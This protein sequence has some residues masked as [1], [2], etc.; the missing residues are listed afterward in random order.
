LT[1]DRFPVLVT[2]GAGYIGSHAVLALTD[3]GWPVVVI[4]NLVTGFRSAV[5]PGVPFIEANIDDA[6]AVESAIAAHGIAAII[7]FAG[8]VVVPESVSDPLK[9][10][11]NNTV[12]S[13]A[14][15]ESA[16]KTGVRH[17]IFSSTA[18]TYGTPARV[19]VREDDPTVPINP[20][21]MSK[22]MT[23]AMLRDTAAAHPFNY[24]ALR[25][26]N[27]AGADR[28][29]RAGQSTRGATHLIK[30]AAEAATGK[31]DHVSIFGTDYETPDGTGVRDYIHVSDLAE[32]HVAALDW[33]VANP[34]DNL[35]ANAGYGRGFSVA[36]VLDAMD[37]VTNMTLE[38]R[39]EPRRAGDPGALIADNS[40]ILETLD[41]TPK[42]A[43]L[44]GIV[45]DALAWERRLGA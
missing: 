33:L 11:L 3:A 2:G 34:E 12:R 5:P 28:Q 22:L 6:T 36:Q 21:G 20:Y 10:Y 39:L 41:W 9:Y 45:S 16:V 38:R 27:V 40:R 32:A 13:R 14:L 43:D 18:A 31:R 7:H 23:E 17:F 44:D 25:Y 15:I 37:R 8:S 29:G 30:I 35:T 24:A 26:F 1:T 4:D 19:P 42:R